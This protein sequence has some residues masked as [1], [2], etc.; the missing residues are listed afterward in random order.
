L[1]H[2]FT[3]LEFPSWKRAVGFFA[4]AQLLDVGFGVAGAIDVTVTSR[5]AEKSPVAAIKAV[6]RALAVIHFVWREGLTQLTSNLHKVDH[7]VTFKQEISC[8]S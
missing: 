6:E 4:E 1:R 8:Y 2:N 5:Y 7:P 3:A